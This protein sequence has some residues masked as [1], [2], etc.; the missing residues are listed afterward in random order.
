[1][2]ESILRFAKTPLWKSQHGWRWA[3]WQ[4]LNSLGLT[5]LHGLPLHNAWID[6]R[7]LRMPLKNLG[8]PFDGYRL[9]QVSDLHF[10]PLVHRAYLTQLIDRVASL[11]PDLVVVTGDLITGGH[12]FVDGVATI[13]DRI[14]A[15][16]GVVCTFGNHDYSM[17]GKHHPE[18]GHRLADR[19]ER[20]LERQG[21][22]VLRNER[23]TVRRGDSSIQIVGLDDEWTGAIDPHLAFRNIDE[24]IPTICLN[25][26]PSNARELLEFPW[27]WMLSGHTHGR[28]LDELKIGRRVVR[29]RRTFVAGHYK[30]E[31]RHLYV[32]RGA[33]Y[34]QRRHRWCRPE[35]TVFRLGP[36]D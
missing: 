26:D 10:S 23:L 12:F 15:R 27:Q 14:N 33:S 21:L 25:H 9:V 11:K 36:A 29:R 24:S 35:I 32:N 5:G 17:L 31:D 2:V 28:S 19:L 22:T 1:M 3:I 16:D 34:G 4:G 13:L 6:V 18:R 30:V 8:K 20:R 7:R